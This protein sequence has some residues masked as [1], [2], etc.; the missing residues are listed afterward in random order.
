MESTAFPPVLVSL[1]DSINSESYL[2]SWR[3]N[4][5]SECYFLVVEWTRLIPRKDDADSQNSQVS[6]PQ[7]L[8]L[9]KETEN[10]TQKSA[11]FNAHSCKGELQKCEGS[12]LEKALEMK[13][14]MDIKIPLCSPETN[15]TCKEDAACEEEEKEP[16]ITK[17]TMMQNKWTDYETQVSVKSTS[18]PLVNYTSDHERNVHRATFKLSPPK[19]SGSTTNAA[20]ERTRDN[21]I[22]ETPSAWFQ[23]NLIAERKQFVHAGGLLTLVI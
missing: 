3:L 19:G 18:K 14:F 7:E 1:I 2:H 4:S 15:E 23:R 17:A 6:F 20:N 13:D 5:T 9:T 8:S 11:A 12:I 22:T 21:A 10:S 16:E